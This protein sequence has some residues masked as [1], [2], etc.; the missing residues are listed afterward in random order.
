[1]GHAF[2]SL[3]YLT[4]IEQLSIAFWFSRLPFPGSLAGEA[5]F[6]FFFFWSI[7]INVS[8]FFS[9]THRCVVLWVS[10]PPAGL[11]FSAYVLESSMFVLYIMSK[12]F[13]CT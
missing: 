12:I 4:G 6:F 1:M 3:C 9:P 2:L 13:S 5:Q 7:L 11:P 8:E 10:R